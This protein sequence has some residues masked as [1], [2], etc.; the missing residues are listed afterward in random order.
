MTNRK[1]LFTAIYNRYVGMLGGALIMLSF[2]SGCATQR[3]AGSTTTTTIE[4]DSSDVK[5]EIRTEY[6]TD[7][8]FIEIPAQKSEN[9]TQDSIS[10]LETDYAVSDARIN[11][12]GSLSHSLENKPQKKPAEFQKP[13]EHKDSIRTI[14][15]YRYKDKN[16]EVP[17]YV[18]K[19]LSWWESTS[20]KFFPYALALILGMA[21][22]IFR[23]PLIKIIKT[24]I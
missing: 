12:D 2:L 18:E 6:V 17:V 19:D 1:F 4:K 23:K 15:K 10:H 7:T 22:W 3:G 11:P 8:V 5:V 24:F 16:V 14:Y 9:T 21:G 13:I 20:I